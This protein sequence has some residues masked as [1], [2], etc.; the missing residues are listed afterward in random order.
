MCGKG[1][2]EVSVDIINMC[3]K[4][5][6]TDEMFIKFDFINIEREKE[7][8]PTIVNSISYICNECKEDITIT[9]EDDPNIQDFVQPMYY[10]NL[11]HSCY[12]KSLRFSFEI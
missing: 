1:I 9:K 8:Y 2:D 11:K 5:K 4:E 3:P 10:N 12:G 7:N 6:I